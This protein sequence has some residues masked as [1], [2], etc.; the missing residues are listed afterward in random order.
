MGLEGPARILHGA[1]E[2]RHWRQGGEQS[3]GVERRENGTSRRPPSHIVAGGWGCGG[4][5]SRKGYAG[6]DQLCGLQNGNARPLGEGR[7]FR[8]VSSGCS[9]T[10]SHTE[11]LTTAATDSLTSTEAASPGT[12][13][14]GRLSS[15][16]RLWGGSLLPR[17]GPA[18][19]ALLACLRLLSF[20]QTLF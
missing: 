7:V 10:L 8:S 12:Q 1:K 3:P 4:Q 14:S 6:Q 5:V 20:P 16:R 17:P 2:A 13:E 15:P 18:A 9:T 19:L 11:W